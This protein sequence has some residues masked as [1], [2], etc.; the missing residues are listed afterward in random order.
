MLFLVRISYSD[1]LQMYAFADMN[2]A[3]TAHNIDGRSLLF[4]TLKQCKIM[5]TQHFTFIL[6]FLFLVITACQ[7]K[8]QENMEPELT[9]QTFEVPSIADN[10]AMTWRLATEEELRELEQK[11]ITLNCNERDQTCQWSDGLYGS[12]QCVGNCAI[13]FCNPPNC[14]DPTVCIG[15]FNPNLTHAG[16]CRPM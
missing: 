1:W 15:C 8:Q 14:Q 12:I 10:S 7:D 5:K 16:A 2:K 13:I 9:V 11:G 6:L 3:P 4:N